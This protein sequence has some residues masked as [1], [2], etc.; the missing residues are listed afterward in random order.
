MRFAG[1]ALQGNNYVDA[2]RSAGGSSMVNSLAKNSQNYSLLS[3]TSGE[4]QSSQRIAGI[5]AQADVHNAGINSLATAKAG[6]FGAQATIAQGEAAASATR[7]QGLAN[8]FG[9][10]GSGLVSGFSSLGTKP[11]TYGASDFDLNKSFW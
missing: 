9:G 10:L 6:A 11:Q 4:A 3:G 7:A 8:M 5:N 2:A 1:M